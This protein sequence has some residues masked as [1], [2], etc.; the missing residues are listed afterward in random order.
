MTAYDP[1]LA[2]RTLFG[3]FLDARSRNRRDKPIIEDPERAPLTY[4]RLLLASL[5]LGGK[6]RPRTTK[7]EAVGV[8]MPNVNGTVALILGLSASGRVPAMLNFTAGVRNLQ[9]ACRTAQ[10]RT[11]VTSRRFLDTAQLSPVIE[12]LEKNEGG[13]G[14][15]TIIYLEDVRKSLTSLEKIGALAASY[16]ARFLHTRQGVSPDQPAVILFTSGSEGTPK[17]VVLSHSNLNANAAQIFAHADGMLSARD[18]VF[19]PLPVFHSF[20]LTAGLLTGLLN[21]M[22]VVLYPSPLHFKQIPKLIGETQSTVLF[23]T[24]TFLQ[25][26]ARA[27]DKDDLS[28]VRYVIAGAEK[29]REE[30]RK[31]W[32]KFGTLILEGY[33]CTECSPVIAC[34]L[35]RSNTPGSVGEILPAIEMRFTDVEGLTDARRLSVRGPNVMLG[36]MLAD[37]PGK[38]QPLA[39]G[40]H[41]TGDIVS[42]ENNVLTIRGRAKRFAK[43][44]GEMI[45]LAAVETLVSGIWPQGAHAVVTIP[46]P[47]KGE[48]IVLVTDKPDADRDTLLQ[49]ARKAGYP[50]LWVPRAI[51]V[52]PALPV[53]GSGKIDYPAATETARRLRP[54]M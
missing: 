51:L 12:A 53:M 8:L 44:G 38:I 50:E 31:M 25:S 19:N 9:A 23:A 43:I 33:G 54:M 7:G 11:I 40:W 34:N 21:G 2:N 5:V 42:L 18:T 26:Y 16:F 30:T 52:V 17:A 49:E 28:Q 48:Q 46:D 35:P 47:K 45:S 22:K 10:I 29:V 4:D 41:D 6:L 13:D 3:A 27:A 39:D 24:D 37:A 1:A 36:Y 14:P 32:D 20:G 15:R